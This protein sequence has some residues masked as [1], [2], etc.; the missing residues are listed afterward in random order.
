MARDNTAAH[1]M[2]R[3]AGEAA[4]CPWWS[5][6]ILFLMAVM[7]PNPTPT[8]P[9][10]QLV[11]TRTAAKAF[12][13]SGREGK[14]LSMHIEQRPLR[15]IKT[16]NLIGERHSGTKWITKHLKDCFGDQV[17]V[18]DRYTR[19]KHWFQYDDTSYPDANSSLVVAMFRDPYDWI[20]SMR[21]RPYHS[22]NHFN[23][24]WK[25]F[26]TTPWTMPRGRADQLLLATGSRAN[27]TCMHRFSFAEVVPCSPEDRHMRNAT[28]RGK[29]VG[30]VYEMR[31][32]RSGLPYESIV[33]LRRD[34][35][36]NF[37][38]VAHFRRV[39]ALLPVQF[40]F[41]VSRGTSELI[42]EIED[43]V[44]LRARCARVP[45]QPPRVKYLEAEFIDWVT[46]NVDWEVENSVGYEMRQ[47][48]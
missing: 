25:R 39:A 42:S 11:V 37:L 40:E 32:D 29:T 2:P 47:T 27:A 6:A 46:A 10:K 26:V 38:D 17:K 33:G 22:P 9:Q 12:D 5:V 45:P 18:L 44:G 28:Y 16:I 48:S 36:Q 34:K 41:L 15:S 3:Q 20:D 4:L 7:L 19:Y 13:D 35:I 23:L 24:D 21:R 43:I 8:L 14:M 30:V 31:H 1:I